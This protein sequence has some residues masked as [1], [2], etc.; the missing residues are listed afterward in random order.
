[1]FQSNNPGN[2]VGS[3]ELSTWLRFTVQTE[4]K[5][6]VNTFSKNTDWLILYAVFR[7]INGVNNKV[8]CGRAALNSNSREAFQIMKNI[9]F[10]N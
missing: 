4:K 1:M 5:T 9:A 7:L 2:K 6:R 8:F 10:T 3:T